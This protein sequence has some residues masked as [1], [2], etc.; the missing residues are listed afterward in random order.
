MGR[1]DTV[2]RCF[3]RRKKTVGKG[4]PRMTAIHN[5]KKDPDAEQNSRDGHVEDH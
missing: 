2:D 1:H 5:I 4:E 3:L